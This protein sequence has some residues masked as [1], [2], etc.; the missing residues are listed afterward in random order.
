MDGRTL[1]GRTPM[2]LTALLAV[3]ALCCTACDFA[4][5]DTPGTIIWDQYA[6]PHI[7]GADIPTV[8]RGLAYA[9]MENHAET[10]LNNVARARGRSAEYFGPGTSNFNLNYDMQVRTYGIAARAQ[11]WVQQGGAFQQSV[12][13][14]FCDGVNEYVSRHPSDIL[15]QLM[16][17]LPVVPS[18]ITAGELNTINWTFTV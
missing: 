8:V 15:P 2:R 16:P 14:A 1:K 17:I 18:D 7:Y 5:G 9:Q 12:L 11:A 13:Q 6:V 3:A 4:L 10:L